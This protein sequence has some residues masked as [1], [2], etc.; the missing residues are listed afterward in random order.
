M[1][2]D[3]KS[4]KEWPVADQLRLL[5]H[6]LLDSKPE[7]KYRFQQ[8]VID[9]TRYDIIKDL[10]LEVAE[11]I[12]LY[13]DLPTLLHCRCVS[14]H[15]MHKV[16]NATRVW[17]PLLRK[18]CIN[19]KDF[20]A[21]LSGGT[22][23]FLTRNKSYNS[24]SQ[25]N[26]NNKE[27]VYDDKDNESDEEDGSNKNLQVIGENIFSNKFIDLHVNNASADTV[28]INFI[29]LF[30]PLQKIKKVSFSVAQNCHKI[31]VARVRFSHCIDYNNMDNIFIVNFFHKS[32]YISL[33]IIVYILA[34]SCFIFPISIY[35]KFINS[36]YN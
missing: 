33:E 17:S 11:H 7:V 35:I 29:F 6:L 13:C 21:N 19:I 28:N 8:R 3:I 31:A 5:E 27:D 23:G 12:L 10:P 15:W 32:R 18:H 26:C 24:L 36:H 2:S 4:Y 14:R 25:Y 30:S 22:S 20:R 16:N 9:F 34:L 1:E